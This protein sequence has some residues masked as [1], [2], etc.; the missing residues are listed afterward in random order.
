MVSAY[1]RVS[2]A[3]P[4]HRQALALERVEIAVGEL[5]TV[6]LASSRCQDAATAAIR[7]VRKATAPIIADIMHTD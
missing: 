4:N 6:L 5:A 7:A 1:S 3:E 2:H